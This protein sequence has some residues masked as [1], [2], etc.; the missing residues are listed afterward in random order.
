MSGILWI[1]L[2]SLSVYASSSP[3][4]VPG[5]AATVSSAA[6]G[7]ENCLDKNRCDEID[8]VW[9]IIVKWVNSARVNQIW[10]S[11]TEKFGTKSRPEI[12]IEKIPI[13]TLLPKGI[14]VAQVGTPEQ[15]ALLDAIAYYESSLVAQSKDISSYQIMVGGKP[16]Y[17]FSGHP[18]ETGEAK[19]S[20]AFGESLT[21]NAAGR[22]QFLLQTYLGLKSNNLFT[23]GFNA[24]EQDKGALYAAR[25]VSQADLENAIKTDNFIPI[26]DKVAV[27]WAGV[28][29]SKP[30]KQETCDKY[31]LPAPQGG[32]NN[33]EKCGNGH[34]YSGQ[35][36]SPGQAATLQNIFLQCLSHHKSGPS[37]T[38]VGCKSLSYSNS[39]EEAQAKLVQVNFQGRSIPVHKF[40]APLVIKIDQEIRAS[41]VQYNFADVG[42][43]AWRCVNNHKSTIQNP[44]CDGTSRSKHSYGIAIDINPGNNPYCKVDSTGKVQVQSCFPATPSNQDKPYD[45][46]QQVIDIF[47]RNHFAWGGDWPGAKDFMHFEW[48]GD[49]GDF[50]GDGVVE[51]CPGSTGVSSAPVSSVATSV[52]DVISSA[53]G[54][55]SGI[56][57]SSDCP[58]GM[59]RVGT[60]C[61]DKYE[62][63]LVNKNTGEAWSPYI[64]PIKEISNLKAVSVAGVPQGYIGLTHAAQACQNADKKLCTDTQWLQACAGSGG[65]RFPYGNEE[66]PGAC[67]YDKPR[68]SVKTRDCPN[69]QYSLEDPLVNQKYALAKTGAYNQCVT[70]EGVYDLTGNLQE[71]VDDGN[72]APS[73]KFGGGYYGASLLIR[74]NQEGITCSNLACFSKVQGATNIRGCGFQIVSHTAAQADYSLGFR[75]CVD[76]AATS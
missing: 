65:R 61:I 72:P 68:P 67:N 28:P 9:L 58:E 73:N 70:P 66:I 39:E 51:S 13:P 14:C 57:G 42:G 4:F 18:F 16:F 52:S 8:A 64:N 48:N 31:G 44:N 19:Q 40:I 24:V 2:L 69:C 29:Y 22:Y 47:K 7:T 23:T 63:T 56:L 71:W 11:I 21:S 5:D 75:C 37:I 15:R 45:L 41:G 50:N 60:F 35:G 59:A 27:I 6:P 12:L 17:D 20:I 25:A 43:Y 74:N 1:F 53:S 30:G 34:S 46:P 49:A 26:W 54:F 55:V 32:K 10:D 3:T 38:G 33:P 76:L 36:G 62:A